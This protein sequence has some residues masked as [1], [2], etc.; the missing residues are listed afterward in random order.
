MFSHQRSASRW[1]AVLCT[2]TFVVLA[3]LGVGCSKDDIVGNATADAVEA[4]LNSA[5][6]ETVVPLN[7]FI[8]KIPDIVNG[9]GR[10]SLGFVAVCPANP[11]SVCDGGGQAVCTVINGN[12]Q[13]QFVFDQCVVATGDVPFTLDGE[14]IATPGDPTI[15]LQFNNLFIEDTSPAIN[16]SGSVNVAGC[17]YTVAVTSDT[18][19]INGTIVQCD[20]DSYPTNQ[21][22]LSITLDNVLLDISFDG[23]N[24]ANALAYNGKTLIA[25]CNINLALDPISS[26]CQ[27][28]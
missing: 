2:V 22:S 16:G 23:S 10:P 26:S 3:G 25:D 14:M 11:S 8:G 5:L 19:S 18:T 6:S 9:V 13:L 28:P 1:L 17:S 24:I 20:T 12:T 21:S 27:A 7:S 4:G 15:N